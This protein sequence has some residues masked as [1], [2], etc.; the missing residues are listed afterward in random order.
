RLGQIASP[1]HVIGGAED[2][3]TPPRFSRAIAAAIPGAR[4]SIMPEVGHGMFWEATEAFNELVLG[5][6]RDAG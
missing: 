4:L 6:I 5:F 2:Q 1:T 3:L